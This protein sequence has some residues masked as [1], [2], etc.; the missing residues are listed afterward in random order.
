MVEDE[1]ACSQLPGRPDGGTA[2]RGWCIGNVGEVLIE[3]GSEDSGRLGKYEDE[4][5]EEDDD[6]GSPEGTGTSPNGLGRFPGTYEG[7]LDGG[8]GGVDVA[9]CPL[10]DTLL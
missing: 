2:A 1:L 7:P 10:A 5:D 9:P 4:D 8:N 3:A 6:E